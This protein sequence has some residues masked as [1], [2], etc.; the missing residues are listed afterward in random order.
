MPRDDDR[1]KPRVVA[2]NMPARRPIHSY[3]KIGIGVRF[4]TLQCASIPSYRASQHNDNKQ[5]RITIVH[6][7]LRRILLEPDKI[8]ITEFC[9]MTTFNRF[10]SA[11]KDN[12][13]DTLN[14]GYFFNSKLL[15]YL[16]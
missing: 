1:M 4:K 16:Q 15:H 9:V 3:S 13:F 5:G 2:F 7:I 6:W 12:R 11:A 10:L 14:L 8:G